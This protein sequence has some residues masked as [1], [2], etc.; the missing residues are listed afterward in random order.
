MPASTAPE[1]Q[2]DPDPRSQP[3]APSDAQPEPTAARV[4]LWRAL[5]L[6]VD[7]PPPVLADDIGRQL[8]DPEDGW[9]DRGDM[10]PVG[11]AGFRAWIVARARFVEH[12]V[13]DRG[14]D[15][16]V[17]LGAGLDTFVQRRPDLAVTTF[18][19]DQPGPQEWKRRRLI[20]LGFGVPDR[21][22]LV[23]FDFETG[24]SWWDVLVASGFRPDQPAVIVSTGVSMYLTRAATAA[25]LRTVAM[26]AAPGSSLA[27]TY[28][29]TDE[30]LDPADRAGRAM[31][32]KGAAAAGTPFISYYA[33]DDIGAMAR[34]AGF[35]EV[36]HVTGP[37]LTRRWFAGR[38]DGLRPSTGEDFLV[39]AT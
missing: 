17:I 35:R 38:P 21:L 28:Q 31:A 37:E 26:G 16:Y 22:R 7:D 9:R 20:E 8:L 11:T 36:A 3:E 2:P 14:V 12:L 15:Q 18:E 23:P 4:A 30:L 13:A 27:L 10:H 32:E 24:G 5:H 6:E 1:P 19:V 34:S 29:L 25:T 39:A 33:P